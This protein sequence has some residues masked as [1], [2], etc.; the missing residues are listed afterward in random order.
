MKKHD[1]TYMIA[2]AALSVTLLSGCANERMEDE[3]GFRDIG[4]AVMQKG[5][6]DGAI[7][8]F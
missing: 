1:V 5:D 8:A 3:L 7:V 4:I 2:V 6:Y